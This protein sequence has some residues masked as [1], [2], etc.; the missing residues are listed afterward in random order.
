MVITLGIGV[1][2]VSD[3]GGGLIAS[4]TTRGLEAKTGG[5]CQ[6][7]LSC[8][9]VSELTITVEQ[10]TCWPAVLKWRCLKSSQG[11]D[12]SE[13]QF[14]FDI[15]FEPGIYL[16]ECL[17]G[18]IPRLVHCG[19]QSVQVWFISISRHIIAVNKNYKDLGH[20]NSASCHARL[21][22]QL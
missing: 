12:A 16:E 9:H 3:G 21:S 4:R 1:R 17:L 15:N 10:L 20:S 13:Q 7:L 8:S 5:I 2:T 19:A 18:W 22:N 14:H 6:I 11:R